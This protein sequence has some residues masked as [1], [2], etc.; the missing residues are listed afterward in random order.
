MKVSIPVIQN[1]PLTFAAADASPYQL[2]RWSVHGALCT[3]PPSLSRL[4][5]TTVPGAL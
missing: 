5:A 3:P 4:P 2:L 1:P